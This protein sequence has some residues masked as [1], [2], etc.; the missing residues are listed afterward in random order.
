MER[1][2]HPAMDRKLQ[3]YWLR[4]YV[5]LPEAQRVA[6][7]DAWL[8]GNDEAAVQRA[9]DRLAG[10]AL[11]S[12]D[13]R[14]ALLEAD[15]AAFEASDDPAVGFAVAVMPT[16][17]ALEEE[18]DARKGIELAAR[19]VYLQAV[20]DHKASQGGFVY[21][22]ANSSLRITFGN[23]QGY[24]KADGTRQPAFTTLEQ[25]AAKATGE[26]PFD[27]PQ[28]QLDAIAAENYGGLASEELG[29]VPVNFMADLDITVAIPVRPSWTRMA[30][31]WDWCST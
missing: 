4:Q 9:L 23:V 3:E 28:A 8:G 16:L 21:P 29:T 6:A 26:D 27:A 10:T 15:R 7:I 30:N 12:L 14:M 20:A 13:A 5:Q 24:T 1:R 11:G 22:D 19:P 18:A 2:Y 17:L 31:S 25:V